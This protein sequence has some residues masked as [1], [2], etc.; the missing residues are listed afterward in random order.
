MAR[1]NKAMNENAEEPVNEVIRGRD[2]LWKLPRKAY[3]IPCRQGK[4]RQ[5]WQIG[6]ATKTWDKQN[7]WKNIGG[8]EANHIPIYFDYRKRPQVKIVLRRLL[9]KEKGP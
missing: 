1:F 4:P 7:L 6:M 9:R 8:R 3:H 5:S 2:A